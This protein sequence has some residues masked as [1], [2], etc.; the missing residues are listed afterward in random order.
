MVFIVEAGELELIK[1]RSHFQNAPWEF[2]GQSM[3]AFTDVTRF[4]QWED[5]T[6]H[7][8]S[9]LITC[10]SQ[11]EFEPFNLCLQT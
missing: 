4:S 11:L 1:I 10:Y 8:V 3:K 7:S 5:C 9:I 2:M 6:Q